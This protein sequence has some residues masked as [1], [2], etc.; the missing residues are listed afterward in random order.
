V[1]CLRLPEPG[2][3][4]QIRK[5]GATLVGASAIPGWEVPALGHCL[6]TL[7][8]SGLSTCQRGG[9][10]LLPGGEWGVPV[11]AG[12]ALFCGGAGNLGCQLLRRGRP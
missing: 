8:W 3:Q 6:P 10:S 4:F 12:R 1:H 2:P 7:D 11:A 9:R 5:V